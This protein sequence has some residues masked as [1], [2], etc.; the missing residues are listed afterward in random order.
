M[1]ADQLSTFVGNH[2]ILVLAFVGLT[3]ALI[4]NE[5]SRFTQGYKMI[6]PSQLTLLINRENALVIDVSPFNDFEKAHIV[7]SKHI[8]MS[9]LDP[10]NKTLAKAKDLPIAVVCRSGMTAAGVAK[11][12]VKAGF[13]KVFLLDGGIAAWQQADLPTARGKQ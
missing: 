13:A 12:L 2:P 4:A 8:A 10:E 1:T 11:R 5:I 6:S 7:G 9:Q 3:I